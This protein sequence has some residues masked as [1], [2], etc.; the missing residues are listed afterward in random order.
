MFNLFLILKN[1]GLCLM[2]CKSKFIAIAFTFFSTTNILMC[3]DEKIS[4]NNQGP[5]FKRMT[6]I[7]LSDD[8][9]KSVG[10][11][12]TT[13]R[14][15]DRGDILIN[16]NNNT[17]QDKYQSADSDTANQNCLC[18]WNYFS[19]INRCCRKPCCDHNS[20]DD[21]RTQEN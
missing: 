15:V 2:R 16:R 17:T 11:L 9:N 10:P 13:T 3:M 6:S 5:D 8:E 7:P 18:F 20:A 21:D 19:C 14:I 12:P 1:K 4:E